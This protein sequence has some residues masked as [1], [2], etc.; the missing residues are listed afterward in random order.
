VDVEIETD[1]KILTADPTGVA[2]RDR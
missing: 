2:R 1:V